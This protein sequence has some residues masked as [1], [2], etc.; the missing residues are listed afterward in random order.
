MGRVCKG[1]IFAGLFA[2]AAQTQSALAAAG[3]VMVRFDA[4]SNIR[5]I[6][7]KYLGNSNLWP[8]ILKATGVASIADLVPGQQISVPVAKIRAAEEALKSSLKSISL[9][10][11]AGAQIFAPIKI[12]AAI[13]NRDKALS[14]KVEGAWGE[15]FS[16]AQSSYA[17]AID[18]VKISKA[19]RD[20]SAQA[21]LSD[22]NGIVEGQRPTELIWSDR[23]LYTK[24]VEEEKVRT[25]SRSTAQVTFRDASRLRINENSQAVIQRMRVDPLSRREETK[26]NLVAGDFYALLAGNSKRK[27]LK[28]SLAN[29]DATI[30]S[31]N[32]WV[33]QGA[34]SAKFTNYD[35]KVVSIATGDKTLSLG[36]NE[37]VV[38]GGGALGQDKF[39]VLPPPDLTAPKD[40]QTVF[41]K[42]VPLQWAPIENA[43]GYWLEIAS[44]P[45][46]NKMI[47]SRW[48]VKEAETRSKPLEPGRYY[49]RIA[50]LDKFG[51]P[52][53]RSTSWQFDLRADQTPPFLKI[54][55][56]APAAILRSAFVEI[57]GET[58]ADASLIIKT[59][60]TEEAVVRVGADGTFVYRLA[61]APGKVE[62]MVTATDPAGNAT[63]ARR[64]LRVMIDQLASIRFDAGLVRESAGGKEWFLTPASTISLAGVTKPDAQLIIATQ[65]GA[66]RANAYSDAQ[67]VFSLNLPLEQPSEIFDIKIVARSGFVSNQQIAVRVDAN[68][69]KISL[70]QRLPRI[71][72]QPAIVVAGSVKQGSTVVLN[73]ARINVVAG[74]FSKQLQLRSGANQIEMTATDALGRVALEK[75]VVRLDQSPPKL[76]KHSIAA[77]PVGDRAVVTV[78]VVVRDASGLARVAPFVVNAGGAVYRG[79]LRYNRATKSYRGTLEVPGQAA[80]SVALAEVELGDSVGNR[81]KVVLN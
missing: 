12:S 39:A 55:N 74:Q 56:P 77:N 45:A 30:E 75:W 25:L 22:R 13:G 5:Q 26:V 8:E 27:K 57:R 19:N 41:A 58:E 51:V 47:E 3:D 64:S 11:K 21:L 60:V 76:V 28:I 35:D 7:Q 18:A 67:G 69:P 46:F 24:L 54:T 14:K 71:T 80:A 20:Q 66:V 62:L 38:V 37:G 17:L 2:I 53:Q 29:V 32:F 49:W 63:S 31:G 65:A 44:D 9:A 4:N 43:Q 72:A 42:T 52:G 1:I 61:A 6:A 40:A 68:P 36:R 59:L 70:S 50:G 73:G 33:R 15:T 16:L 81:R 78:N 79:H 10:N 34:D 23:G 48:G